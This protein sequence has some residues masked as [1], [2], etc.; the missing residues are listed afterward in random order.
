VDF[1]NRRDF[2]KSTSLFGI[3]AAIPRSAKALVPSAGGFTIKGRF[4]AASFDI[5]SGTFDVRRSDGN[6]LLTGSTSCVNF[7][8]SLTGVA[9]PKRMVSDGG[10]RYTAHAAAYK[11]WTPTYCCKHDGCPIKVRIKGG[12]GSRRAR[13][14]NPTCRTAS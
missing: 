2:I 1:F 12:R 5:E 8:T 7:D 9:A 10:F 6:H 13:A 3:S 11:Y 14:R 4:F